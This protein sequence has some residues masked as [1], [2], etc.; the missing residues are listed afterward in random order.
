MT[1]KITDL[2]HESQVRIAELECDIWKVV[3]HHHGKGVGIGE[4]AVA[5]NSAALKST[6]SV[7]KELNAKA[8]RIEV[9]DSVMSL[10]RL[11]NRS[12]D[13]NEDAS[14]EVG[15]LDRNCQKCN[16]FFLGGKDRNFCKVCHL[17]AEADWIDEGDSAGGPVERKDAKGT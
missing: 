17:N 10:V 4:I 7:V 5:L 13:W 16:S 1:H 3:Y 8:D 11:R 2:E 12:H 9:R 14:F 15:L 6:R